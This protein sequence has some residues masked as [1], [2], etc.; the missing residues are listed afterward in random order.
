MS[1]LSRVKSIISQTVRYPEDV[2]TDSAHLENE[3]GIDSLK[4]AEIFAK[5]ARE[6]GIADS[7]AMPRPDPLT[8]EGIARALDAMGPA[9]TATPSAPTSAPVAIKPLPSP[10]ARVILVTGS[11]RGL[12]KEIA[13]HLAARGHTL[14][15]NSFH[16]REEGEAT[17]AEISRSG[18]QAVHI[19]G[20]V[21]QDSHLDRIFDEIGTRFGRL[22]ALV[23]NAS[24][25]FIGPF[26]ELTPA[27]W[28]KG[29]RTNVIGL[30][31]C[32]LRAAKLMKGGGRIVTL[33]TPAS[34]RYLVDFT[35]QGV[36]KAAVETLTR[37]LAAELA[38]GGVRV[39]CLSAGPVYGELL[40][41]FP[42]AAQVR[43]H[44]ES[45]TPTG[46]LTQ[47]DEISRLIET[48]LDPALDSVNGAVWTADGGLSLSIDSRVPRQAPEQ[49]GASLRTISPKAPEGA[50]QETAALPKK[51]LPSW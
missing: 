32:A 43:E 40:D 4:Q 1:T 15:V 48:L 20:S 51:A 22:D 33:S 21:A 23:A 7:G 27:H 36:I 24:D 37:Y 42:N 39:N 12:G 8:P 18:G 3:L 14:I 10:S 38:P 13:K 17:A 9:K 16:S 44:W 41:K 30:H 2:I 6:W 50:S 29:F 34:Q 25:G 45:I 46:H 19:W 47:P 31:Q 26:Q 11:G 49:R 35:C 5:I 28:E